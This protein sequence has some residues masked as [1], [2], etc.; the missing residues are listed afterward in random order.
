MNL[1]EKAIQIA[2]EAHKGQKDKGGHDYI[3][4]P[5]RVAN[6]VDTEDEKIV[7]VL[8]DTIEDTTITYG[9]LIEEGFSMYIIDA[10]HNVTRQNGESYMDFI[11]RCKQNSIGRKVKLADLED[12]MN[13]DRIPNPTQKDYDRLKKYGKAKKILLEED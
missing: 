5:L 13:L 2:T 1:L 9:Y 7:A 3:F 6:N 10:I 12:N 8:H 11:R 4:H